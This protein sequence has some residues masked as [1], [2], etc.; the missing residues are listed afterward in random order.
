MALLGDRISDSEAFTTVLELAEE[1]TGARP[2][3][4]GRLVDYDSALRESAFSDVVN[5][6]VVDERMWTRDSLVGWAFSTS[7]ASLERL[8]RTPCRVRA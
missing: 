5:L 8:G 2:Q 3:A 7:F 4:P 1:L 6:S